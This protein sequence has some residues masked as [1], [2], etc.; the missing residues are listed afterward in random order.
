MYKCHQRFLQEFSA[1]V[2][3]NEK[4]LKLTITLNQP[5]KKHFGYM[6]VLVDTHGLGLIV[7]IQTQVGDPNELNKFKFNSFNLNKKLVLIHF[8]I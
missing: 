8:F 5:R 2:Y 6:D 7:A 3:F 1:K 4:V